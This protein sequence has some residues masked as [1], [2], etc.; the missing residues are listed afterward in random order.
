MDQ[1]TF[2][3]L[4][5]LIEPCQSADE[6]DNFIVNNWNIRLPWDVLDEESTSSPLAFVWGVYNTLLTG[7]GATR[8]VL[9]ASRNGGKTLTS[10]MLQWFSMVHFRRDG[11]HIAA[12]LDQSSQATRYLD[13]FVSN[14]LLMPYIDTDNV[15]LKELKNLPANDFTARNTA[16]IQVVTATKKGANAPRASFMTFD[17]VD[18]TPRE[19]LAEAAFIADPAIQYLTEPGKTTDEMDPRTWHTATGETSKRDTV[20]V[21]LSSRKTN[22]GPI[23]DLITEGEQKD[24]KKNRIKLHKW[25]TVDWMETCEPEVHKP[26]NGKKEAFLHTETLKIIWGRTEFDSLVPAS[27]RSQYK[28]ISAFEGCMDCSAFIACQGRSAKQASTSPMLR[29]KQFVGD[30]LKAVRDASAIIAQAL[31]WRPETTG[32]VFKN[33]SYY[34][35]VKEPIEFYK[36]VTFGKRFNPR[37]LPEA[38]LDRIEEFGTVMEL[39]EITPTKEDCYYAMV[40]EGWSITSG[41]DW[42]FNP[43]PAVC[44]LVGWH[45]KF[46][47]MAVFHMEAELNHANHVWAEYV[48]QNIYPRFPFEFVGPDM[49]D[50]ASPSYFRKRKIRSLDKK[51]SR[52]ETG[53]SHIRGLLWDPIRAESDFAIFDDSQGENNNVMLIEAMQ[54]WTHAKDALGRWNMKKF[55]DDKWTHSIDALRYG[56]AP[57]VTQS[58]INVSSRQRPAT[59]DLTISAALGSTEAKKVLEKK[60]EVIQQFT[61]YMAAEHGVSNALK[62]PGEILNPEEKSEETVKK[63]G[64]IKFRM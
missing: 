3:K 28:E 43:D 37:D 62:K 58:D 24:A 22:D 46:K 48:A 9:A 53:V 63:T 31:N 25:S 7:E 49:A 39:I 38:E 61:D 6:L 33:F 34:H 1:A 13:N 29:T 44:L 27:A 16:K 45:K 20:F 55:A 10:S 60:N 5:A 17:E 15:K 59:A 18:L 32:L 4:K 57:W 56:T 40:D 64:G 35:H 2:R 23:Q 12:T 50:P 30:V 52:I 14:P 47:K 11:A 41:V 54:H 51:P 42:G 21:Y 36:W 26:E 8:H 19:I